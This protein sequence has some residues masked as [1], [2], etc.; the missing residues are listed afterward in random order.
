MAEHQT[1]PSVDSSQSGQ[2]HLALVT[3]EE[4]EPL[5]V[6]PPKRQQRLLRI[7]TRCSSYDQFVARYAETLRQAF[8]ASPVFF[9]FKRILFAATISR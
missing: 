8:P 5:P 7:L 6:A 9:D 4:A 3:S 1:D 2:P